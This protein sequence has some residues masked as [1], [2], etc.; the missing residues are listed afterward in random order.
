MSLGYII[1]RVAADDAIRVS[2]PDQRAWLVDKINEAAR[3][4][5][6]RKDLPVALQECFVALDNEKR[7]SLPPFVGEL[8]AVRSA[9]DGVWHKQKWSIK[10]TRPAYVATEWQ[11]AWSSFRIIGYSPIAADTSNAAPGLIYYPHAD[12]SVIV[13]I[14]GETDESN[15]SVDSI[16][17]IAQQNVWEKQFNQITA[18]RKNKITD[19]NVVIYGPDNNELAIIYADQFESRY[20]VVD[21]SQFPEACCCVC[22]DGTFIVQVLY[23]PRLPRM[24]NDND[25]FPVDGFDDAIVLATKQLI[26][27]GQEGKEQRAVLMHAKLKQKVAHLT[28]HKEGTVQRMITFKRRGLFDLVPRES[29]YYNQSNGDG[30]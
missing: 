25:S 6:E 2:N 1:R 22:P 4:L 27:E 23:K 13:S 3:E 8:R 12:E 28:E 14:V 20:M 18:I 29:N 16:P 5:Y 7:V 15:R 9:C 10:D 19:Y 30:Y 11:N 17:L 24:E 21:I 26:A